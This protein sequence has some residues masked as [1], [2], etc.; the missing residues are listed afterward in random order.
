[1]NKIKKKKDYYFKQ[2]ILDNSLITQS[3]FIKEGK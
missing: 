2:R 1:M 3:T